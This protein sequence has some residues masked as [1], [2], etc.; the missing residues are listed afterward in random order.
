[1]AD[2]TAAKLSCASWPA[3]VSM[4]H[5]PVE[6]ASSAAR[7]P[8]AL[9]AARPTVTAMITRSFGRMAM[10]RSRRLARGKEVAH[11]VERAHD[12]LGGVGI[13]QAHVA[14]TENAEI[15]AADDGDAGLVQ[16]R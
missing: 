2:V 12:V 1:M 8:G 7:L 11:A 3:I 6:C 10:V 9:A 16:Q 15:G 4:R 14:F 13:G 5:V